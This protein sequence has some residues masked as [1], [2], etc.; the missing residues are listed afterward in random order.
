MNEPSLGI[1]RLIYQ[2]TTDGILILN[3]EGSICYA[4]KQLLN[5]FDGMEKELESLMID[6]LLGNGFFRRISNELAYVNEAAI[7]VERKIMVS[8]GKS[9]HVKCTSVPLFGEGEHAFLVLVQDMTELK[10]T[11]EEI[12]LKREFLHNLY[13]KENSSFTWK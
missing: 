4:N 11:Q 5:Y 10:E 12:R 8:P 6:S 9:L 3:R 13:A 7:C 1:L 2:F